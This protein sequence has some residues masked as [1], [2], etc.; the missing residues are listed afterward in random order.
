VSGGSQWSS[1]AI[2]VSSYLPGSP[3]GRPDTDF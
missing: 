1:G 2:S 3:V